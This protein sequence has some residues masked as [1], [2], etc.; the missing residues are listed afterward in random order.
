MPENHVIE[1]LSSEWIRNTSFTVLIILLYL[2]IGKFLKTNDKLK[3]A[4]IISIILIITTLTGH[5]RNII[6][7]YWNISEN[8]PLQLCGISNLIGC[9]I[10]F[11]PK[12]KTLF[13]FFYYAGIIGAIQAFL[14]P[15]INNFDGTNYE[16]VEY[17]ISHGGILLL[18]IYMINN[19]GYE[20]RKFSWLKV[21]IYLNILLIFIMPLNFKINSNYMYLAYPPNV[22]NPL[23][24]GEWPYYIMYWE[25]IIVIFTYTLYVI[26][27]RKKT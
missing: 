15:Q 17:Y 23:I 22:D 14:T 1:F 20:L 9:F 26:S 8:L 2:L 25:I 19:L 6:N 10:L 12:N 16:Y 21:L 3:F 4:K 27:T 13:E 18:P 24:I 5:S 11:I 7:G